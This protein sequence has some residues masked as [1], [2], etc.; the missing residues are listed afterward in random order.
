METGEAG[1]L[2][3]ERFLDD[4]IADVSQT[5]ARAQRFLSVLQQ[6]RHALGAV[7]AQKGGRRDGAPA[8]PRSM[9]NARQRSSLGRKPSR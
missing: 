3:V 4:K 1:S 6:T 9:T 8:R 2:D 5:I 7:S